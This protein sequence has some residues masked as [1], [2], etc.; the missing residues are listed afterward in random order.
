MKISRKKIIKRIISSFGKGVSKGGKPFLAKERF[1]PFGRRRR[2]R[3]FTASAIIRT[4]LSM[5]MLLLTVI[6]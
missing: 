6:W 2:N 1:S 3:Y 5:P 4:T